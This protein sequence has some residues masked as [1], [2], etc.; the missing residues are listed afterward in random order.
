MYCVAEK[1]FIE[2]LFCATDLSTRN[3]LQPRYLH[4]NSLGILY[5]REGGNYVKGFRRDDPSSLHPRH[6][7]LSLES[8][9]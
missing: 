7:T 3:M 8:K 4:K 5:K 1:G 9:L 6:D 2:I